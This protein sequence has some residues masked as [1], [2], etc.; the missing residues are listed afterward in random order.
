MDI[1]LVAEYTLLISLVFLSFV[2]LRVVYRKSTAM[3]LIGV[4]AFSIAIATILM[5]IGDINDI[6]FCTDIAF[7]LVFFGPVGTI[8][9]SKAMGR[10]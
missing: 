7:A 6:G 3:G 4:S 10:I 8:A 1:F 2:I 5:I 9:L